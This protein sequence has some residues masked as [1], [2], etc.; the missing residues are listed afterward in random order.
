MILRK[1][2]ILTIKTE[3]RQWYRTYATVIGV[4]CRGLFL[5]FSAFLVV[6]RVESQ[7]LE[8]EFHLHSQ[9]HVGA[10]KRELDINLKALQFVNSFFKVLKL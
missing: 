1:S 8:N 5:A 6:R 9:E 2:E 10:L 3:S 4:A 7:K